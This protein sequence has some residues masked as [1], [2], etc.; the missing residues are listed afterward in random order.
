MAS[1]KQRIS[2]EYERL[3]R[4]FPTFFFGIEEYVDSQRKAVRKPGKVI[5]AYREGEFSKY[6]MLVPDGIFEYYS[7]QCRVELRDSETGVFVRW[8][9]FKAPVEDSRCE[10]RDYESYRHYVETFF[11][12][13]DEANR[14]V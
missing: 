14:R 3:S 1:L 13:L 12:R 9:R 7:W 5:C 11:R 8:E 10:V 2:E 6:V 4:V